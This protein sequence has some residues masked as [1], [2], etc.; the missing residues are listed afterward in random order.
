MPHYLR[1]RFVWT[2]NEV[3]DSSGV[4][5]SVLKREV[6][7]ETGRAKAREHGREDEGRHECEH[8]E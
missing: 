7:V 4:G 3:T 8:M 1:L 5:L 6:G 2:R